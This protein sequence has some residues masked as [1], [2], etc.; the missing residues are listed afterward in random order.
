VVVTGSSGQLGSTV[1]AQLRATGVE[2]AGVDARAGPW[3]DVVGDVRDAA[4]MRA[5]LTRA[6]AVV[7]SASLHGPHVPARS[8]QDFIDV[9]VAGTQT[10]LDAARAAGVRRVV[11]SSTTS[12]YGHALEPDGDAAVWVDE[13]LVPRPRDIYDV[14]KLAAERLCELFTAETGVPTACLRV[15][16]FSFDTVPE[17]EVPYCLH[18]A[19]NVGDA[20]RA[21]VLALARPGRGHTVLNVSGASPFRRED[22]RELLRDAAAVLRR[23]DPRLADAM[24]RHG[25]PLP[26][27]IERVYAIGR[28]TDELG[29]RPRHGVMDLLTPSAAGAAPR[30]SAARAPARRRRPRWRGR[31]C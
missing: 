14:T 13:A 20:A 22:A 18:R 30:A 25:H 1:V 21:H 16:R 27:R 5:L 10:L 24:V 28:A 29:Y 3:T 11:F 7:H 12:V 26:R 6:T 9:N 15:S 2:V 17:L 4:A 8:K 23:R 31:P 19:V